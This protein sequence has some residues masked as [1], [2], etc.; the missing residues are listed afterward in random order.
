MQRRTFIKTTGMCC[1]GGLLVQACG[2]AA[3]YA[4]FS[5]L[6]KRLAVPKS[7]FR[8]LNKKGETVERSYVLLKPDGAAFPIA[9]FRQP[10]GY[11][12]CLLR[13]T[14]QGCEVEVQ[15]DRYA[16]PCHGSEFSTKGAVLTGPAEQPLQTFQIEEDDARIYILLV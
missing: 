9:L 11:T 1:L 2:T 6:E 15:G 14:H 13:C 4:Q 10:D 16:C 3:Y 7:E 12:A 5:R 8:F